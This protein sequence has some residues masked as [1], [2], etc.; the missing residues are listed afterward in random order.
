M[1]II[2]SGFVIYAN[3]EFDVFGRVTKVVDGDT[4]YVK[5]YEVFSLKYSNLKG[6]TVKVRFADIDAPELN[7]PAGILA[8]KALTML[9]EDRFCSLDI[10]D[11][12]VYDKYGRIIAV[13]YLPLNKTHVLNINMWLILSGYAVVVN[14]KNEFNPLTWSLYIVKT[15]NKTQLKTITKTIT[16]IKTN[17]ITKTTTQILTKVHTITQTK[18][19]T[20]TKTITKPSMTTIVRTKTLTKRVM[21]ANLALTIICLTLIIGLV[22]G[23]LIGRIWRK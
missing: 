16:L 11:I 3:Y 2:H 1:L 20:K 10:D 19:A 6:S 12:Y 5:I 13:L 8:K 17:T 7:T 9:V 21:D 15:T 22:T 23:Y 18:T 14:Y 4:V